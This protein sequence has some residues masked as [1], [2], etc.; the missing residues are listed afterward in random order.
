MDRH[1]RDL[2]EQ[3]LAIRMM[4]VRSLFARF[5]RLVRDIARRSAAGRCSR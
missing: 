3:V 5:P 1:A 4:P 2:H